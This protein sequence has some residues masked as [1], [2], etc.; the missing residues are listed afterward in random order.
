MPDYGPAALEALAPVIAAAR[1]VLSRLDDDEIPS[2]VQR[3]AAYSGG[4]LPP[5][6]TKRLIA[7][8]D[9][10]DWLRSKVADELGDEQ[11]PSTL[12]I[13]R[14]DGWWAGF[15]AA[16]EAAAGRRAAGELK[17]ATAK[18]ARL[19]RKV[20]AA[21]EKGKSLTDQHVGAREQQALK[22]AKA[23]KQLRAEAEEATRR[24]EAAEALL[25]D[26][27]ANI[28]ALRR[29]NDDTQR[30]LVRM[31]ERVRKIRS[32]RHNA[33]TRATVG[34]FRDP[35]EL[36][37]H[38]DALAHLSAPKADAPSVSVSSA[39]AKPIRL[40][41]GV[42]PDTV[43]AITWLTRYEDPFTFV[44][45]GYN[46]LFL[47]DPAD[48]VSGSARQRLN[49]ALNRLRRRAVASPRT[50]VV[51]D[52]S[53]PGERDE[54][55]AGSVEVWFAQEDRLA[56]EEVVALAEELTGSVVVVSTD[57]EVREGAEAAGAV[58]LW[59]ESLVAWIRS[60]S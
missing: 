56:D 29:S 36:A 18:I 47:L 53:L 7:A 57:R 48:F 5:P 51:Y 22:S 21:K 41:K 3:V 45:D 46:V 9:T 28:E 58:A 23:E 30:E 35:L 14:P 2:Q 26:Q 11:D 20:T 44:V 49:H 52:S 15:A 24:L 31:R 40:P 10:D 6:L 16:V 33:E 8:L 37:R 42:A 50:I 13:T 54:A 32:Q 43:Q 59:S 60:S 19:E 55:T 4:R 34:L 17:K 27:I 39:P 25:A 12:F 38:L 1:R